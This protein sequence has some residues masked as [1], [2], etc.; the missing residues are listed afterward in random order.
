MA[1]SQIIG[2]AKK[3]IIKEF[4]KDPVILDAIG[5]EKA[6]KPEQYLNTHI[7]NYHQNPFTLNT[8]ET[9][10][11]VQ[12]HIPQGFDSN[13]TYVSPTVEIWIIS[14]EKHMVVDNVPKIT[15]NR[16]DYISELIDAKLNGKT[17]FGIGELKLSSNVEGSF[18]Q[19][20][21]YRRMIFVC[22]DLNKSLCIE[23]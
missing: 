5:S 3:K 21:L 9:F 1:N 19:D 23:E 12:V 6:L 7:F 10:V 8:V 18:Q 20:Y 15:D 17:G 4:I 16:N 13:K 14:H 22:K 2:K 11:T